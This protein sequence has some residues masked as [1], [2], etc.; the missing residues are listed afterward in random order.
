MESLEVLDIWI[1]SISFVNFVKEEP[2]H[3]CKDEEEKQEKDEHRCKCVNGV[4]DSIHQ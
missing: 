1:Y 4:G 3:N 2:S